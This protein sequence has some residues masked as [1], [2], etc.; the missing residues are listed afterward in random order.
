MRAY[1][2]PRHPDVEHPDCVDG[3]VY[4]L[5]T[6]RISCKKRGGDRKGLSPHK[7]RPTRIAWKRRFRTILKRELREVVCINK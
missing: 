1:G 3:L 6:C 4:A 2:L 5:K 7:K